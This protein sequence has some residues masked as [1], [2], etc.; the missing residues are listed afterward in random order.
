MITNQAGKMMMRAAPPMNRTQESRHQHRSWTDKV[1]EAS[2]KDGQFKTLESGVKRLQDQEDKLIN[3]LGKLDPQTGNNGIL[4]SPTRPRPP[5]SSP[6]ARS[7]S[8]SS[9]SSAA[10]SSAA[11]SSSCSI[12]AT[13]A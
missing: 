4:R 5:S 7:S 11:S 9:A 2:E 13:T 8:S 3:A 12:A 1:K 6:K 10:C